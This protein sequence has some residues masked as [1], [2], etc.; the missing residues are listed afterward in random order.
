MA[1]LLAKASK[2][3]QLNKLRLVI[4]LSQVE[5]YWV[6]YSQCSHPRHVQCHLSIDIDSG[7][8]KEKKLDDGNRFFYYDLQCYGL[9][10]PVRCNALKRRNNV[11]TERTDSC[12]AFSSFSFNLQLNKQY[13]KLQ[14]ICNLFIVLNKATLK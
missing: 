8:E 10:T 3:I 2:A 12:L 4:N 6:I 14:Q 9:L 13:Y 11:L 7:R 1:K 5:S